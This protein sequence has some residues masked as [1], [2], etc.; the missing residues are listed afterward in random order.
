VP[1]ASRPPSNPF[2]AITPQRLLW[3]AILGLLFLYNLSVF[4]PW[5]PYL[6][7]D[8]L[9]ASWY[10]ALHWAHI[11]GL[12]F[13]RDFVFTYGPWGFVFQGYEPSTYKYV[14]LGWTFLTI[15][16]FAGMLRLATH[17]AG[18]RRS[19][20]A[21]TS[22]S[23][24]ESEN[25]LA[26]AK[27]DLAAP[28]NRPVRHR[29]TP[30]VVSGFSQFLAAIWLTLVIA[31]GGAS[32]QGIQDI[33]LFMI[34]WAL[35]LIDFYADDRPVTWLKILLV[36]ASAFGTLTKFSISIVCFLAVLA[37]SLEQLRRRQIPWLF[38]IY[39][40][41]VLLLWLAASQSPGSLALYLRHS[42]QIASAYAQGEGISAP[43]ETIS[44]L[45]FALTALLVL[46]AACGAGWL[47]N[48]L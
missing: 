41:T 31:L 22:S 33:R 14:V 19:P 44:I 8:E 47:L 27:S 4:V 10:M 13:G 28:E 45:L 12:D 25:S 6:P 30:P 2:G 40:S 38:F 1:I 7:K 3:G 17:F 15:A 42:W 39:T 21:T 16:F 11:H 46:V 37:V 48:A 35:L 36:T 5:R 20:D 9:D 18:V 24:I 23:K 32:I 43:N 34:A 29:R 26:A